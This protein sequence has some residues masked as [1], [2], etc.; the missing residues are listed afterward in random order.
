AKA[1]SAK[2]LACVRSRIGGQQ[3]KLD[4]P[5]TQDSLGLVRFAVE[6]PERINQ[7]KPQPTTM[8]GYELVVSA[9]IDG[10]PATTLRVSPG[11]VPNL[12]LRVDPIL[13]KP[14]DTVVATLIRGPKFKG[15][16]P[17][18][19][20]M[21]QLKGEPVKAKLD[22]DHKASFTIAPTTEGW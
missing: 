4:E 5:A 6:L 11:Q 14:G 17:K 7:A 9:A 8:L 22:G 16:L 21:T 20:V 19:L 3:I 2:A 15:A 18:E 1:D 13:A 10:K 12:R